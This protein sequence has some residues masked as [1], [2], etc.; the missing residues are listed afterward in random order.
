VITEFIAHMNAQ[1]SFS[2]EYAFSSNPID[3]TDDLPKLFIYPGDETTNASSIDN[4]VRQ[5]VAEEVNCVLVSP[6]ADYETH[7][8]SVLA[9]ALG[10]T[11]NEYDAFEYSGGEVVDLKAGVLT[12]RQTFN[13]R[14]LITEGA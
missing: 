5:Q 4:F 11:F 8:A 3:D 12:Y 7:K 13:T 1:L 14:H 9:A 10:W 2:A 6:I